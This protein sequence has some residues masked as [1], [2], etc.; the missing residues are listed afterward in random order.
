MKAPFC[1][2]LLALNLT[3]TLNVYIAVFILN[4]LIIILISNLNL[5]I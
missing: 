4:E 1:Q 3:L 5:K 2:C